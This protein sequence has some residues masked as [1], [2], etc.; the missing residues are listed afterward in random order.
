MDFEDL[1]AF[2]DDAPDDPGEARAAWA[3]TLG[4]V[5]DDGYV[6]IDNRQWQAAFQ[7]YVDAGQISQEQVDAIL[8]VD[9]AYFDEWGEIIADLEADS[10]NG[11]SL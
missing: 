5:R 3:E 6:E 10:P 1:D 7:E 4:G 2:F 9:D 8:S 11:D